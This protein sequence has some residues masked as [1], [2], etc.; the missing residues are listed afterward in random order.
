MSTSAAPLPSVFMALGLGTF[1]CSAGAN[2]FNQVFERDRDALMS[3]T[4]ARPLP[5]G[6]VTDEW[7]IKVACFV[8]ITGI[9]ILLMGTNPITALLGGVNIGLYAMVYTKLK[10]E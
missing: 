8:S 3:R 6:L 7:A 1:L 5:S 4:R 10:S 9:G 2:T